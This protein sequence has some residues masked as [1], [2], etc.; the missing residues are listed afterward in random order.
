MSAIRIDRLEECVGCD[1][2][3]YNCVLHDYSGKPSSRQASESALSTAGSNA[4][5]ESFWILKDGSQSNTNRAASLASSM[6][7]SRNSE[8]AS[9]AREMLKAGLEP[10][11]VRASS[12]ASAY[13]PE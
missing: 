4:R 12:A 5:W 3:Q 2:N 8:A 1:R 6:R 9:T 7:P 11:A 10:T 13:R